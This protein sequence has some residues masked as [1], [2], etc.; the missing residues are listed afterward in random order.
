MVLILTNFSHSLPLRNLVDTASAHIGQHELSLRGLKDAEQFKKDVWS[1]KRGEGLE[2]SPNW[3]GNM[4]SVIPIA[5][6]Q[7]ME[8]P[9]K[10]SVTTP[11]GGAVGMSGPGEVEMIRLMKEQNT[12]L[13]KQNKILQGIMD[14]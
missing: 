6:S 3:T 9:G 10:S 4:P 7:T 13:K 11:I 1:M 5:A 2:Y 14:K 12:L 8:R